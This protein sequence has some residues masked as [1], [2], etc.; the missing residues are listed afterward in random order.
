LVASHYFLRI[1]QMVCLIAVSAIL[2]QQGER[3]A[4]ALKKE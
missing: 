4:S 3:I 2:M 1:A